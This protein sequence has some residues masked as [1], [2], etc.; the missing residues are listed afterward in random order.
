MHLLY[1]KS[2][3]PWELLKGF[4]FTGLC[5]WGFFFLFLPVDGECLVF[6]IIIEKKLFV[7]LNSVGCIHNNDK[8]SV[9]ISNDCLDITL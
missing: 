5:L 7:F 6:G 4:T 3:V 8:L 1:V 2:L 9:V